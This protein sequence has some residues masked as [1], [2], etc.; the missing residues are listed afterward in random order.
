ML[1]EMVKLIPDGISKVGNVGEV[2]KVGRAR[3]VGIVGQITRKSGIAALVY[4]VKMALLV[5]C[6]C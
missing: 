2:R 5:G 6:I 3:E 1:V 4:M